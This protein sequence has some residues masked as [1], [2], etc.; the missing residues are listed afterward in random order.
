MAAPQG[1]DVHAH[2]FPERFL[3]AIEDAGALSGGSIHRS[4]PAGPAIDVK[5]QRTPPLEAR[6]WDLAMRLTSMNRQGVA[7]QALSLT[8]PMVYWAAGRLG[9]RLCAAVE[10]RRQPAHAAYPDRFVVCATLPMQDTLRALAELD[11]AARLPGIRAVYMGTN[12]NGRDLYDPA[13]F[14]VLER[15][16]GAGAAR[17]APPASTST[18]RSG[19]SPST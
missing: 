13:F 6:Y 7:V 8:A 14:P 5:G 4:S 1:I 12:V 10:R 2:F 15:C 9:A 16:G 17:A 18:E 19:S 3:K 11:R